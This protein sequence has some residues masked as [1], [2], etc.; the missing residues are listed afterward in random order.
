VSFQFNIEFTGQAER[1]LK[2]I[3]KSDR[4]LFLQLVPEIDLLH[5]EPYSGKALKGNLLGCL[6]LRVGNYR[7][8]YEVYPIKKIII[9]IRIGH[10]K[11]IYR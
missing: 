4:R 10:R 6:S 9:V 8:I 5:R 1:D 11:D 3:S 7:I 2:R